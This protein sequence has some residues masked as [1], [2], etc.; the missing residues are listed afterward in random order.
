MSDGCRPRR[1]RHPACTFRNARLC[2]L[3]RDRWGCTGPASTGN[4]RTRR[5]MVAV[6]PVR[7]PRML[8]CHRVADVR[9]GSCRRGGWHSAV[10]RPFVMFSWRAHAADLSELT[11]PRRIRRQGQVAVALVRSCRHK[12]EARKAMTTCPR[13]GREGEKSAGRD[14]MPRPRLPRPVVALL[15]WLSLRG[16]PSTQVQVPARSRCVPAGGSL[17]VALSLVA[18]TAP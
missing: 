8:R 17:C 2:C 13:H 12:R 10:T 9:R 4:P 11:G 3:G 16:I 7:L 18:R 1:R 6:A 14:A 15:S 5:G